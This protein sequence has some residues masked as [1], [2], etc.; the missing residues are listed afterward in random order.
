MALNLTS[1]TCFHDVKKTPQSK[2]RKCCQHHI[3]GTV[4]GAGYLCGANKTVDDQIWNK[5]RKGDNRAKPSV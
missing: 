5:V 3:L 4:I 2:K 1:E